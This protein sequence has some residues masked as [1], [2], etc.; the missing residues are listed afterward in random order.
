MP[1]LAWCRRERWTLILIGIALAAVSLWIGGGDLGGDSGPPDD[2][3]QACMTQAAAQGYSGSTGMATA[4]SGS[5][6]GVVEVSLSIDAV[7]LSCSAR[8]VGDGWVAV[9]ELAR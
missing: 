6:S 9:V 7:G 2:A 8:K 1:G 3:I 4:S 5:S